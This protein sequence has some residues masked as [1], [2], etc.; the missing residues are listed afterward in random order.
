[1]ISEAYPHLYDPRSWGEKPAEGADLPDL[2]QD[3]DWMERDQTGAGDGEFEEVKQK[4][5]QLSL[6]FEKIWEAYPTYLEESISIQHAI[7][8]AFAIVSGEGL[9]G[10]H[11][12]TELFVSRDR[13]SMAVL[14]RFVVES[15][16]FRLMLEEGP[17]KTMERGGRW[18]AA[19]K[20]ADHP[21]R[22][23]SRAEADRSISLMDELLGDPQAANDRMMDSAQSMA[24]LGDHGSSWNLTE[25]VLERTEG[26][27]LWP[28]IALQ[29]VVNLGP[30]GKGMA[31]NLSRRI[32]A[33]GEE[34][35]D[36]PLIAAGLVALTP[37]T[38]WLDR[39][40]ESDA[41]R[42]RMMD[43]MLSGIDDPQNPVPLPG[44]RLGMSGDRR[45]AGGP[46][47][48]VGRA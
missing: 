42:K 25:A 40:K 22:P 26:T 20:T 5:A 15:L 4:M 35:K 7:D 23:I 2:K 8:K 45:Q 36:R 9:V 33:K 30:S 44:G 31:E 43:T 47:T 16:I 32:M 12:V 27:E 10:P 37:S 34:T 1:M 21:L 28:S 46:K 17:E 29:G 14:H 24:D 6:L 13:Q 18:I 48:V 41:Y 38:H 39:T 11:G 19:D 3:L